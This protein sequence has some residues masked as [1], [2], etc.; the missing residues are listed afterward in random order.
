M[1]QSADA[2][3]FF[4]RY[5]KQVGA[6][7]PDSAVPWRQR[8]GRDISGIGRGLHFVKCGEKRRAVVHPRSIP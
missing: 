2:R 1:P 4:T 7:P 8:R 3:R 6:L 5:V